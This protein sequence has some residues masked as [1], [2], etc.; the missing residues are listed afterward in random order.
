MWQDAPT[1]P[2]IFYTCVPDNG[3][4]NPG[5]NTYRSTVGPMGTSIDGVELMFRSLL[6]TEPW[7]RDPAVVPLPFRQD[8]MDSYLSRANK[9]GT[10]TDRPLKLGVLWTNNV[11]QPHPPVSRGLKMM[12]DAVRKAGHKVFFPEVGLER[13]EEAGC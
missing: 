8:V 13:W 5:Q 10:A 1:I 9:D 4:Q 6:T 11:V 2:P 12:V 7:L 3:G